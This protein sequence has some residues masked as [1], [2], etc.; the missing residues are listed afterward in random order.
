MCKERG[1]DRIL[2]TKVFA[3]AV[4]RARPSGCLPVREGLAW[5]V[6][7][8]SSRSGC[9]GAAADSAPA[10][11][12][13]DNRDPVHANDDGRNDHEAMMRREIPG[14]RHQNR[15]RYGVEDPNPVLDDPGER[16]PH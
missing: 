14:G 7:P 13:D 9:G 10:L 3:L 2:F 16:Y 1:D 15:P 6:P 4:R 12:Q 5:S 11:L 8:D